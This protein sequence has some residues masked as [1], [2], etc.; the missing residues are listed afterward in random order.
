VASPPWPLDVGRA[1]CLLS[2]LPSS[3]D[4]EVKDD[5]ALFLN[6]QQTTHMT[7]VEKNQ[8]GTAK[9]KVGD[10]VDVAFERLFGYSWGTTFHLDESKMRSSTARQLVDIFGFT[11]AARILD[12]QGSSK[13]QKV[14]PNESTE[15]LNYKDIA[16]PQTGSSKVMETSIFAGQAIQTARKEKPLPSKS[17]TSGNIDNLLAKLN[18]PDKMNTVQKTDNDWEQ[19]KSEHKGLQGELEEKAQSKDAFLVK[20]DFLGRVDQR[21][22]ELEKEKRDRERAKRATS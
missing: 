11:T 6:L 3:A 7:E 9:R 22:F 2:H 18:G 19:W 20:Q 13:R 5:I 12:S 1:R 8:K 15:V 17:G 10:N 14:Q 16:L 21:K 4:D